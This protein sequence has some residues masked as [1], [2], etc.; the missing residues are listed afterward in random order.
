MNSRFRRTTPQSL[1]AWPAIALLATSW[2]GCE[3]ADSSPPIV[4]E[5]PRVVVE[6][7]RLL[8]VVDRVEATG[9]LV[10]EAEAVVAAQ[11]SGQV[12]AILVEDGQPVE[13]DQPLFVVK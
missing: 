5:A 12:T 11:V 2:L 13:F 8:D 4:S 7:V 6:S 1:K 3:S 9:E 10:A